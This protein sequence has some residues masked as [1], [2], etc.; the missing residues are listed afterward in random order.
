MYKCRECDRYFD[1]PSWFFEHGEYW[2]APYTEK[3]E[4]CPHCKSVCYEEVEEEEE[5]A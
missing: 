1:E 4:C 3:I 2:G 5:D